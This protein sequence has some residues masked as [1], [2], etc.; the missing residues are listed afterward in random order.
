[1]QY[2]G[3]RYVFKTKV[4]RNSTKGNYIRALPLAY[5]LF[6]EFCVNIMTKDRKP[7]ILVSLPLPPPHS[8]VETLT[9]F[10][11]LSPLKEKFELLHVDSSNKRSNEVRGRL[12]YA[13]LT[14][15]VRNGLK[16]VHTMARNRPH[17]ANIP[18]ARNRFGFIRDGFYILVCSL[19]GA[20]VV[21]RMTG[22]HF[23]KYYGSEVPLMR[24]FIRLVLGRI[25]RIIV[26]AD[27]I[28]RQFEGLYPHS[29]IE[30][31]YLPFDPHFFDDVGHIGKLAAKDG[32]VRSLFM[33]HISEAKG[34]FDLLKSIP[35]VLEGFENVQF[36]FAGNIIE[37][38]YNLTFVENKVGQGESF[39]ESIDSSNEHIKY[40]DVIT[41]KRKRELLKSVDILVLP[42]YSEG[43]PFAVLEAMAAG[44]PVVATPVG[45]LPEVFK[46]REN[47]LFV[48]VGDVEG[49]ADAILEL[50]KNPNLR[51]QM[52]ERNEQLV[53]EQFNL[54]VFSQR[55]AS[56]YNAV[57]HQ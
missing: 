36:L 50:V 34:A 3:G 41:G 25:S 9:Q 23:D 52:G 39:L 45:A 44:L 15:T 33:G 53:R 30:T 4:Q 37:K 42:S 26:R 14:M 18:I 6:S 24:A 11:L 13:N 55:M 22:D 12:D 29:R 49:L 7:K 2:R 35:Q 19:M 56:I 31:V 38:E 32:I 47:I 28:R 5:A 21:S 16:I 8:G 17:L 43:F 54:S 57:L 46:D 1:V 48:S 10:F 51:K 20:K 40:L 27:R